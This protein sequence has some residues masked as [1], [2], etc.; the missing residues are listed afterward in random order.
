MLKSKKDLTMMRVALAAV[1]LALWQYV[2]NAR[3]MEFYVSKPSDIYVKLVGWIEDGTLLTN[4]EATL[5]VA[6][7]GFIIG[8]LAG[9]GA[10]LFLG[11][12]PSLAKVIDPFLMGLY[13]MPKIALAPVFVLWFG[14]DTGM[15]V[16]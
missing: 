6:V 4:T 7:V 9:L 11:R 3:H 1:L 12:A 15:K 5:F 16:I 13:S 2:S 14:V 10:G 8:S